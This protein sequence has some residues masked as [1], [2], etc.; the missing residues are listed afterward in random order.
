MNIQTLL[1]ESSNVTVSVSPSDLKEFALAVVEALRAT[2]T[3]QPK[4]DRR[5]T[6]SEAAKFLGKS[7]ATLW[8]WQKS[9]YLIPDG[10]IGLQP[11]YLQS[12]LENL[13]KEGR[14]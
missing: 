7:L 8:R 6:Q 5:L 4:E 13:G 9:G 1:N 11:Y 10:R 12:T 14:L 3:Q 2:E